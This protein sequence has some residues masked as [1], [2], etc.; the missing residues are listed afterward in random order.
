M[1]YRKLRRTWSHNDANYIPNF[2]KVFPELRNVSS[3][4]MRDRWVELGVDFYTEKKT[5]VKPLIRLTLPFG[6][7]LMALMLIGLPILFMI[8]GSWYYGL[9]EKNRILNWFRSLHLV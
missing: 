8:T 1:V 7:L 3:E 6:I 2:Y 4:E 9:G 5:P